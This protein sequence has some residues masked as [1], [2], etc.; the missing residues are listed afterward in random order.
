MNEESTAACTAVPALSRNPLKRLYDWV[1]HWAET[2]YGTPALFLISF[3]ESS[4][5]PIPPDV[6]QI[7]LSMS[8]PK[9]SF[10]YAGISAA[11]SILGAALG[12]VIGAVLWAAVGWFFFAYVPG[13]THDNF[14]RVSRL[15]EEN[16]GIAIFSAAFTPI[17]FKVF[18][19]AAGV[20]HI[21]FAVMLAASAAGR[22]ARFFLVAACIFFFGPG[23][24]ALLERYFNLATILFVIL[25]IAGFMVIKY[26]IP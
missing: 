17:P 13:F 8:K 22:S 7:A 2:P 9:R 12:W 20:C 6:L 5:F 3:T 16:A 21:S 18:T 26:L 4:V 24:K 10:V 1:L 14:E 19:I 25:F 23:V 11:G 15:Y